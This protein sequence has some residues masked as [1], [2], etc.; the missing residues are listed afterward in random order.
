MIL[1][2]CLHPELS[3]LS[4]ITLLVS[5]NPEMLLG[6]LWHASPLWGMVVEFMWQP[7]S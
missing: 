4:A 6:G 5:A 1:M 2:Y 3:S 7:W